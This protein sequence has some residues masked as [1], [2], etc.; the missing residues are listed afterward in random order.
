M[1]FFEKS[2][3]EMSAF[4]DFVRSIST[5][6]ESLILAQDEPCL[7]CKTYIFDGGNAAKGK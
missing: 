3:L 2:N 7:A 5:L 1:N 6:L 4:L